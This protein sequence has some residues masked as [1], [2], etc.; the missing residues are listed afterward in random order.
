LTV[1]SR[2]AEHQFDALILYYERL[3]RAEA[4]RNLIAAVEEAA[5]KIAG[6]PTAG[7]PAPRPYPDLIAP[8]RAWV[9]A[10]RYWIAYRTATPPIIT[11]IFFETADIPAR[12]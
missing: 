3:G 12:F 1:L 2:R 10:G 11:G 5:D 6:D 9:K 4:I 8:R 7:V